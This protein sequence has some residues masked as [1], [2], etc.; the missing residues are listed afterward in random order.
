MVP[1]KPLL[2]TQ[3]AGTSINGI[4]ANKFER[5]CGHKGYSFGA[6]HDNEKAAELVANGGTPTPKDLSWSRVME[7]T[8]E[9]IGYEDCDYVSNEIN[10]NWCKYTHKRV[11]F[12]LWSGLSAKFFYFSI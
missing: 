6:F 9:D 10:Y 5:V 1:D 12:V 4:A 3:T 11:G 8:M 7:P 2:M